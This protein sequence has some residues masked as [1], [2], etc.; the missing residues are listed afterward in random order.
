MPGM[1]DFVEANVLQHT[2]RGASMPLPAGIYLALFTSDP[3][4]AG[5]GPECS[6]VAWPAYTRKDAAAGG[7]ISSG[8]TSPSGG[9]VANAKD[10]T[11]A[12]NNGSNPITV[13]WLA[14][15][16]AATGGNMLY[17][18][19]LAAAKVLAVGDVLAFAAG[20]FTVQMD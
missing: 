17:S 18:A 20:S 15:Y 14:L 11:F 4:D 13:T 12:A 16:D 1:S 8:W 10:I 7:A 6:T 2:L 5:T 19:P 3:T 9:I